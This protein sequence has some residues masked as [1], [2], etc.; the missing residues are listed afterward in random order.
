MTPESHA[1]PLVCSCCGKPLDE[2]PTDAAVEAPWRVL[3]VTEA[4]F[5]R[6]VRLTSDTCVID[7]K[8][9]LMR[10]VLELPI[11]G[12]DKTFAWGVWCSLSRESFDHFMKRW[13][14]PDWGDDPPRFGW[15]MSHLPGYEQSTWL[16][17]TRVHPR[18]GHLRPWIEVEPRSHQIADEQ[19][20]GISVRRWHELIRIVIDGETRPSNNEGEQ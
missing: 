15:L 7:D 14:D 16:L 3:D 10:G 2:V 20:E 11:F 12:T 18:G 1:E 6:R 17:K 9:F 13:N 5:D 8:I 4:E 19:R